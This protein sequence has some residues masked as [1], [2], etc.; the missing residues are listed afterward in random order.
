MFSHSD[1]ALVLGAKGDLDGARAALREAVRLDPK[2][3]A[4]QNSLAWLLATGPVGLR[5]GRQAVGYATR[6]CELTGWEAPGC[7][8]NLAAA[9][10]EAGDFDKAIEYLKKALSFPAYEKSSGEAARQRLALYAQRKLLREI[11]LFPREL[12]PPPREVSR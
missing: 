4:S 2:T 6:A 9:Y 8:A 10:A 12:A 1:L 5:D 7:I 11:G 3:G